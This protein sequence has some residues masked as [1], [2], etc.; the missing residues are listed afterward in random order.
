MRILIWIGYCWT[1][2]GTD[3]AVSEIPQKISKNQISSPFHIINVIDLWTLCVL[4]LD[5]WYFWLSQFD[6]FLLLLPGIATNIHPTDLS[7]TSSSVLLNSKVKKLILLQNESKAFILILFLIKLISIHCF[8]SKGRE[9]KMNVTAL[10]WWWW[11]GVWHV[12]LQTNVEASHHCWVS[13]RKSQL[14]SL[15]SKF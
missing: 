7:T 9:M 12:S 13:V 4:F 1:S 6:Y 8:A 3:T 15:D 2:V 11:F 10:T 14:E 5:S